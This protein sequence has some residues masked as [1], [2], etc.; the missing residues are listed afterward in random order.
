MTEKLTM[1]IEETAEI[2]GISRSLAYSLARKGQLPGCLR[3]GGR[4]IVSKYQLEK[5][6][7][8]DGVKEEG[9]S[10]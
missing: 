6:L 1:T 5:Y 9:S 8:G 3:L 10:G 2:L 7:N 4:F